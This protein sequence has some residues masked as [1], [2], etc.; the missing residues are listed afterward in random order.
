MFKQIMVPLD[1]SSFAEKALPI[2]IDLASK[3]GAHIE[4]VSVA[5]LPRN[6]A[7]EWLAEAATTDF[8]IRE[9]VVEQ[10]KSYLS[11]KKGELQQQGVSV[12]AVLY[13][14][15]A[16]TEELLKAAEQLNIDLIV[17]S[18]HGRSGIQLWAFGSVADRVLRHSKVPV[19]LVRPAP[20]T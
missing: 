20:S 6:S 7:G 14:G 9:R 19:L 5:T 15:P 17:M 16:I 18:T 3:Y 8:S 12:D 13:D 1:G 11:A 4:L 2:A 10:T